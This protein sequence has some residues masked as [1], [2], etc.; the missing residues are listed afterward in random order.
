MEIARV[1]VA[2]AREL[3]R[4]GEADPLP[5]AAALLVLGLGLA[6]IASFVFGAGLVGGALLLASFCLLG[7]AAKA[8][9]Y[10]ALALLGILLVGHI[11]FSID[12]AKTSV[13]LFGLPLYVTEFLLAPAILGSVLSGRWRRSES[14]PLALALAPFIGLSA[15]AAALSLVDYRDLQLVLYQAT[16]LFYY[17]L[18]GLCLAWNLDLRRDRPLVVGVVAFACALTVGLALIRAANGQFTPT[19]ADVPR[20]LRGDSGT[21]LGATFVALLLV[22]RQTFT[23]EIRNFA[24]AGGLMVGV[25]L[26]E[27]RSVWLAVA[28]ALPVAWMLAPPCGR[29]FE[30]L[31]GQ[32]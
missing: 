25:I 22:G 11:G 13:T 26:S 19:T 1:S 27:H 32:R 21:F 7:F 18:A 24:V 15:L 4:S 17:P 9:R 5:V 2:P 14:A 3:P 23:N 8:S 20:Y 10:A 12:F 28:V 6:A 31:Y 29:F 30:H 16:P